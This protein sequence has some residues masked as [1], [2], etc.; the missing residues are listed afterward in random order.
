MIF[1]TDQIMAMLYAEPSDT[2]SEGDKKIVD[3]LKGIAFDATWELATIG[4][5]KERNMIYCGIIVLASFVS[6]WLVIMTIV[7]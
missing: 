5:A 1:A 2:I 6:P 4:R 7:D 3:D